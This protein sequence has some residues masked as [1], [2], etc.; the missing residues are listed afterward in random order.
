MKDEALRRIQTGNHRVGAL[1]FMAPDE[2]LVVEYS[3][4]GKAMVWLELYWFDSGVQLWLVERGWMG[5]CQHTKL[6]LP[7]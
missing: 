4:T 5:R 7:A 3:D 6:S 2:R 1:S